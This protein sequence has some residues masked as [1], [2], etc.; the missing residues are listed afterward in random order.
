VAANEFEFDFNEEPDR[1]FT[2]RFIGARDGR[3]GASVARELDDDD[4]TDVCAERVVVRCVP[5]RG[6][7][8]LR[9]VGDPR[10]GIPWRCPVCRGAGLQIVVMR[11]SRA[12]S[13]AEERAAMK[14]DDLGRC[15][16]AFHPGRRAAF[17]RVVCSECG[18]RFRPLPGLRLPNHIAQ[19][20][21]ASARV[22]PPPATRK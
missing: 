9:V 10:V 21:S 2:K 5:C 19:R 22:A 14:P 15:K 18:G 4:P 20:P 11:G 3:F 13:V 12:V 6:S 8:A 7:G 1:G 17:G 16:G